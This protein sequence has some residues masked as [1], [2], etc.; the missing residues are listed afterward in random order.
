M[1]ASYSASCVQATHPIAPPVTTEVHG[2]SSRRD[3]FICRAFKPNVASAM[4][5]ASGACLVVLYVGNI[6]VYTCYTCGFPDITLQICST[7]SVRLPYNALTAVATLYRGVAGYQDRCS[8]LVPADRVAHARTGCAA[9]WLLCWHRCLYYLGWTD[10]SNIALKYSRLAILGTF[11]SVQRVDRVWRK[12]GDDLLE[13]SLFF[14]VFLQ[15]K[16]ICRCT[17]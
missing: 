2:L 17:P 15:L 10:P 3:V 8:R 14:V 5:T 16:R 6:P 1:L 11:H 9:Q 13:C 4:R 12:F 7:A